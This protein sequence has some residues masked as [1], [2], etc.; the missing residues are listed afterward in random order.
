MKQIYRCET[1]GKVSEK[2]EECCDNKMVDLSSSGCMACQG[3]GH[4]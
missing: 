1:C 3:C 2:Q 4:H